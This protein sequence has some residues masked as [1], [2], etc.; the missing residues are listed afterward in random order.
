MRFLFLGLVKSFPHTSWLVFYL[1]FNIGN[2]LPLFSQVIPILESIWCLW[3]IC[4]IFP[5]DSDFNII[6]YDVFQSLDNKL[7]I[8]EGLDDVLIQKGQV[9]P[10][11][12]NQPTKLEDVNIQYYVIRCT[13]QVIMIVL[14]ILA[15][16]C[17]LFLS[18]SC[19]LFSMF[20]VKF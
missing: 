6:S 10:M 16:F 15:S 5:L 12:S 11:T 19:S 4:G 2:F 7:C 9:T 20:F 17:P 18:W 8:L 3:L 1:I 13:L 14:K